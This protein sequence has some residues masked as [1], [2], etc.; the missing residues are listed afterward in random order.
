M[1][2]PRLAILISGRGPNMEALLAAIRSGS[3][4]AEPA[5]VLSNR[6]EAAG[7]ATARAAGVPVAALDHRAH[8]SRAGVDQA[9][10]RALDE[11]GAELVA[12]AGFMRIM[13]D[14]FVERWRCRMV[15]IHPSLL[16]L[17]SGLDTHARARAAGVAVHGCTVHEVVPEVDA[18]RI[19]G[20]GVVPVRAGDTPDSLAD[21]VLAME[22]RLYPAALAAFIE[23]PDALRRAPIALAADPSD[24][25]GSARPAAGRT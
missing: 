14:A 9:M 17:F 18:G 10:Q 5:L 21:R 7:L 6:P 3:L 11:A 2:L 13:T 8:A 22:H 12:C 15:N 1:S 4:A 24:W 25:D 20:Q 19:L 23:D 16:P